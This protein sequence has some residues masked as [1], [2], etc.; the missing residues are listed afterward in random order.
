ML[1]E[2]RVW[3]RD[4]MMK[5]VAMFRDLSGARTGLPDSHLPECDRELINVI[6]FQPPENQGDADVVSPVGEDVSLQAAIPISEGFNMGFVKA[7]PG[8]GP[9]RRGF[10]PARC[11]AAVRMHRGTRRRDR[12]PN[13]VRHRWRLT[14][15]RIQRQGI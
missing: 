15:R 5:R 11:N 1:P 2:T 10:F 4:E 7:E 6:G 9:L 8:K 14:W 13:A 3:T 12:R